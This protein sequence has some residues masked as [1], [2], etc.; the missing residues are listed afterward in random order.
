MDCLL[1]VGVLLH[2][3]P[4]IKAFSIFLPAEYQLKDIF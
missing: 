1:L 2:F 4:T 3:P